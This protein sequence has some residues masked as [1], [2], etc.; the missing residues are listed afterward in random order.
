MPPPR[1]R[2]RYGGDVFKFAGDAVIILWQPDYGKAGSNGK[3]DTESMLTRAC[4]CA[5]DIQEELGNVN[6]GDPEHGA[7][8][9]IK[10]GIG[11]GHASVLHVGGVV[12]RMEYLV[13]GQALTEALHC[14]GLCVAGDITVS[15]SSWALV[16]HRCQGNPIEGRS[17]MKLVAVNQKVKNVSLARTILT[18]EVSRAM[19]FRYVPNAIREHISS[20]T[21]Q[22]WSAELRTITVLFVNLGFK[23][24]DMAGSNDEGISDEMLNKVQWLLREVQAAVYEMEGSLNKFL[25]DDKRVWLLLDVLPSRR[26]PPP[27]ALQQELVALYKRGPAAP[28]VVAFPALLTLAHTSAGVRRCWL[29]SAC[30]PWRTRRTPR[31]ECCSR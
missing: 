8:F 28:P 6:V 29:A 2:C 12:N 25:M 3:V 13:C 17:E 7:L 1:T 18:T 26:G 19:L 11:S 9:K 16:G 5:I 31:A 22:A 15:G 20:S 27:C 24:T 23:A 4:Q 30:S 21:G 10:L 14:E